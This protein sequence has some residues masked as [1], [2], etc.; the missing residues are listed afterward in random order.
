MTVRRK[1]PLIVLHMRIK[2]LRAQL[3]QLRAAV[4]QLGEHPDFG[5]E[6][7]WRKTWE[8]IVPLLKPLREEA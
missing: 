6:G 3:Q 7:A 2:R 5:P 8:T 4:Y 1:S